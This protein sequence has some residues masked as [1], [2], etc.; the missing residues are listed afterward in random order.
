M[1]DPRS[2]LATLVLAAFAAPLA[3]GCSFSYSSQ[4]I[5]KSI[6]SSFESSSSSSPGDKASAYRDDVRDYTYAYVRSSTDTRDF[7]RGLGQLAQRHGIASWESDR[8]TWVGI[9]A[10]LAKAKV[11]ATELEV[12]KQNLAAPD[13]AHMADIQRGYEAGLAA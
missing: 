11:N 8:A 5:S 7:L 4:S 2:A 3:A 13:A 6:E 9:G 10:G 12:F 1:K